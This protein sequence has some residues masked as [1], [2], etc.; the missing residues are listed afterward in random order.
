MIQGTSIIHAYIRATNYENESD[1]K[2]Q[3]H[4]RKKKGN[5]HHSIEH[6]IYIMGP[7]TTLPPTY[8][9]RDYLPQKEM[10]MIK[11]DIFLVAWE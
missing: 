5:T 1:I 11:L 10:V 2:K 9:T 8:Y 6:R 3:N 7:T 4:T